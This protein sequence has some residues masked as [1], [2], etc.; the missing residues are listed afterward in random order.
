MNFFSKLQTE[1][2]H[3]ACDY[4]GPLFLLPG[5]IISSYIT[6]CLLEEAQQIEIVRYIISQQKSEGGWGL[7][8]EE[9]STMFGTCMN[10]CALRLLGIPSTHT[11]CRKARSFIASQ[12]GA[13]FAPQWAKFWLSVLNV[14]EWKGLNPI[15]PE[16]WLLP[17]WLPIHPSKMWNHCRQV[18]LPMGYCYGH[19]IQCPVTPLILELR[20]ELYLE[21]YEKIDWAR[22]RDACA[23]V[24]LYTPHSWLLKLA[25]SFLNVYEKFY[26]DSI[27]KKSLDLCFDHIVAEDFNSNFVGVGPVSKVIN[28]LVWWHRF[29]PKCDGLLKHQNRGRDN[30]FMKHDGMRMAGTDGV[31]L[32]DTAFTVC[33]FLEAGAYEH[34][35]LK[36]SLSAAYDF[37]KYTQIPE[38]T[39]NHEKYYRHISKGGFPFSTRDCGWIVSDC[40]GE[41]LS[42][43]LKLSHFDFVASCRVSEERLFDCVNVILSLRNPDGSWASY[44]TSRGGWWLEKL[45]PSEVFGDIMI[46]YPYVECTSSCIQ[47]LHEFHQQY[48]HHRSKEISA[49]L[50]EGAHVIRSMQRDDGSWEGSWGVCFTYGTWFG[51][52]GLACLG[53]TYE[54]G[55]A[56]EAIKKACCFLVEKQRQDGGWGESFLVSELMLLWGGDSQGSCT[57]LV[58]SLFFACIQ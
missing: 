37:I 57:N 20:E 1:D 42:A 50:A 23:S 39:P 58:L 13:Y 26:V 51:I 7:H 40:C 28:M 3:W 18:Y 15:I 35:A 5:L 34:S 33:A 16:L 31:Q 12:G 22:Y 19:K 29:G 53:E 14:Y 56:T 32:W 21:P 8:I 24:D 4:G 45:N 52:E 44:E 47:A 9:R 55:G 43:L 25:N 17:E 38:N 2:G 36:S 30:L 54:H 41:G 48:P 46:D 27:R 6:G 10:Y 11:V 49:A